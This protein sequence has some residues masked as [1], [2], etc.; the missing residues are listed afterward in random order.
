MLTSYIFH[1][2]HAQS[3]D[4]R[5]WL[6]AVDTS[7]ERAGIALF[8]GDDLHEAT[9]SAARTQT[10]QVLVRIEQQMRALE[11][12]PDEL[13]S[14]AVASGPGTF[15]GLRVGVS[16]AKGFALG[17]QIPLLG[18]PTLRATA[19]PWMLANV[20]VVAV[21]P[22]GR[23][24]LVWQSFRVDHLADDEQAMPVNGTPQELLDGVD[25]LQV[26][27]I[28]GELPPALQGALESSP[29]PVVAQPGLGS[30]IG[31]IARLGWSRQLRGERDDLAT[32]EPTYIHGTTQAPRPVRDGRP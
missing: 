2:H 7:A 26:N 17:R 22:A 5:P 6:L 16:L 29:V 3:A 25:D 9:W 18:I 23:G 24:R 13:G 21:L 28:V 11:I 27:A 32:L 14:V 12:G 1:R 10:T 8:D 15:T 19:L 4:E 31:A 20:P 30:R